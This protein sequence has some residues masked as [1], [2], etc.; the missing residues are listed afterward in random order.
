MAAPHVKAP[1]CPTTEFLSSPAV[2]QFLFITGYLKEQDDEILMREQFNHALHTVA[3][4][5]DVAHALLVEAARPPPEVP[6][7]HLEQ[8]AARLAQAALVE[9]E[10]EAQQ[11]VQD[12]Q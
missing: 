5:R 1:K 8:E 3:E 10:A 4:D 12:V 7:E 2:E 6:Q 9:L 11:I